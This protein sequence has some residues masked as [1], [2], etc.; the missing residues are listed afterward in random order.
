MK[1]L[2][3]YLEQQTSLSIPNLLDL[4]IVDRIRTKFIIH[5]AID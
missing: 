1:L 3:L 2:Q 4:F 5:C